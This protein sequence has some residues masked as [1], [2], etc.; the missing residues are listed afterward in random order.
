[1]MLQ[2]ALT[3]A[4]LVAVLFSVSGCAAA[5][6]N[7]PIELGPVGSGRGSLTE[8]RKYLEGRWTLETFEVF[9]PGKPVVTLKGQGT[10]TYDEFGNLAMEIRADQ[11]ASD[12]LRAAGIA[13]QDGTISSSG[14]TAVDMQNR[15]L[16]YVIEGQPVGGTG[17]LAPGRP[18]HWQ[19]EGSVLTLTTKD[20]AGNPAS[21]GR[22]R[23]IS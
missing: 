15:T 16:T 6:I 1:M 14:R 21:V 5:P 18:R 8:A 3:R 22:W 12:L 20:D 19:V 23:K 17:P 9:P 2:S 13:I 4:L 7:K 11:A 10:L